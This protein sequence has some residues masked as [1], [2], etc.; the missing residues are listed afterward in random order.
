MPKIFVET[1]GCSANQAESEAMAGLLVQKN[2]QL[3]KTEND[4]DIVLINSC[5]VKHVT[6]QRILHRLAELNGKKKII[7]AGCMS[8]PGREKILKAAPDAGLISTHCIDK[9]VEVAEKTLAGKR[10]ELLKPTN[11][12]KPNLPKLRTNPAINIVEILDGCAGHCTYCATKLAKGNV[13]SFSQDAI[14]SNIRNSI[15]EG[16]REIWITSQDNAAYGFDYG[17]PCLPELLKNICSIEGKFFVRVGM[18][19][20]DTIQPILKS[21]INAYRSE[22]I[23]KFLHI[24]VQSASNSILKKMNRKYTA[25]EFEKIISA[26]RKD[27][28]QIAIWTDVICG[29]PGETDKQFND[30]LKLLK[31]MQFDYAN[32]S[33]FGHRDNTLAAR[34]KK[35]PSETVKERTKKA[36]ELCRKIFLEKNKKWIGWSGKVLVSEKGKK[37]G[38]FIARNFA[39]KPIL[40]ENKKDL[41]GRFV[42]AEI[43]GAE[44]AHLVGKIIQ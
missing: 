13:K 31:K 22:K 44:G 30:T 21:L 3:A 24:P 1:Y 8:A 37:K 41:L 10:T 29:F 7:V 33:A 14:I 32:V 38:Q 28:P 6:E 34:M 12:E 25:A 9:I 23:Y 18:S 27:F 17:K 11:C 19:N 39:Y 4:A 20:P 35:L 5:Y 2:F 40:L 16:A 36:S 26:F 15:R 43:S 42:N